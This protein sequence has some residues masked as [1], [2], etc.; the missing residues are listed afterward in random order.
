MRSLILAVSVVMALAGCSETPPPFKSTVVPPVEWGGNFVMTAQDGKRFD[1]ATLNGKVQVVF[2]GFTH[3]PDICAPTLARLAQVMKALGPDSSR[4][5][6][7]FVSVDPEHDT[8]AQL[9]KYL[10][11]FEPGFIGLTGSVS[12]SLAVQRDHKIFSEAEA[13]TITHTS[14]VMVKDKKGKLRL[15]MNESMSVPD[16]AHDLKLLINQ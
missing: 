10:A 16:M 9:K 15:V 5:Q 3:C 12:E 7:L 11:G 13:Q 1:T 4:V 6:V 14:S 2:F 8:P